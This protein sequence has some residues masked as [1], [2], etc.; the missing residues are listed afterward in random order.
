MG[1]I[2]EVAGRDVWDPSL[3]TSKLF[4]TQIASVAALVGRDSGVQGPDNDFVYVD[5]GT[6]EAFLD[7]VI[8]YLEGS[9]TLELDAML[10]GITAVAL[11]LEH[12]ITGRWRVLPSGLAD[13]FGLARSLV[14]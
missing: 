13:V 11:A 8:E 7:A 5:A 3:D 6:F 10:S 2:F 1:M 9:G 14:R 4:C 12:R